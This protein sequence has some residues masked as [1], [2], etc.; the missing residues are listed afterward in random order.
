M[1]FPLRV[2][3]LEDH[4]DDAELM[5]R[6]LRR[7]GFSP[8]WE[9]VQTEPE[10]LAH[11]QT[12]YFDIVLAD[13]TLP[14][15][16]ALRALELVK[17][18]ALDVP[19]IIVSGSI[20]EEVAVNCM[21]LGAADYL[22]KDRLGRLGPAVTQ[23]LRA[24]QLRD[25]HRHAEAALRESEARFRRLAENAQDVILRYNLIPTRGFEYVSPAVIALSGYTPEEYY[26]NPDLLATIVHPEDRDVM[27]QLFA[28]GKGVSQPL[29]LRWIHKNGSIIWTE[30]RNV[31]VHDEAGN[32]VAI[33]GITRD[34]TARKQAEAA[35]REEAQVAAAL[36]RI[37]RDLIVS[38]DTPVILERLCRLTAAVLQGDCCCTL[39]WQPQEEGYLP[40]AS[41]GYAPEQREVLRVLRVHR[42]TIAR[43]VERLEAEEVVEVRT[44]MA[45]ALMPDSWFSQFGLA[46]VLCLPLRRGQELIGLHVCGYFQRETL[47]PLQ[48]RIA[49]GISQ[50]A[51]LALANAKL[52]EELERANN[53]KSDFLA[54]MSHELR[55]PLNIIMGYA[56]LL[57]EGEFG[58]LTGEQ[59]DIL[60]RVGINA[61]ELLNLITATLDVSRLEA[62][63]MPVEIGAVHVAK[64]IGELQQETERVR[65]KSE[66]RFV[67][68][69]E[70]GLPV[71]HT[72]RTKLK[73]I[74]KNLINNAIKFTSEG[75]VTVDAFACTDGVEFWVS[76]TGIGIAPEVIPEIFEMFRQADSSTTRP[77]GGVGLGLYIVRR[78]LELLGGTVSVEST[79]GSGSTFRVWVPTRR[80]KK[81]NG[82]QKDTYPATAQLTSR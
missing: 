13:Y 10:Y 48:L 71:L 23:A 29:I 38:L 77:Y 1:S 25:N 16:D 76:D 61:R 34:I 45:E 79:V 58:L 20:S 67:W 33:E 81:N 53:L 64:L 51:S 42:A 60:R 35:E 36:A 80:S 55:T 66:L 54:T 62:G 41:W 82:R 69:V 74:L 30:Q 72:D 43:L 40:A 57:L 59:S 44:P 32:L 28:F 14:Q 21:K 8:V 50:I 73:V 78:L 37:G 12:H 68:R 27:Q 46:K 63:R 3:I 52:V 6:E 5:L 2:L 22:L 31:A 4:Q 9:W 49:R 65:D 7:E 18:R 26:D 75:S 56:D 39:L 15:F 19:F 70:P 47:T 24:K 11:L 17:E